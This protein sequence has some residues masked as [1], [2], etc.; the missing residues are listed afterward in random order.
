MGGGGGGAPLQGRQFR[1]ANVF[2]LHPY[3]FDHGRQYPLLRHW[4]H[5]IV[6]VIV[7]TGLDLKLTQ[8]DIRS[9]VQV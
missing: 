6:F 4:G 5:Q 7:S 3:I 9:E 2:Q 8:D 1:A